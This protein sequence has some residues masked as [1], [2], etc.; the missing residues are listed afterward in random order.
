MAKIFPFRAYRYA[1]SAGPLEKL[2]TQPYDKISPEMQQRYLANDPKN[3]VRVILGERFPTDTDTDNVYTRAANHFAEWIAD[4]TLVQDAEAA[5]YAYYQEFDVPDEPG[6]RAVRKGLIALGEVVDYDAEVV[7]RHELTLA[8]PKKDRRQVLEHTLAHFGQIFMLYGDPQQTVDRILDEATAAPPLARLTDEYGVIHTLWAVTAPDKIAAI[9][10]N[11]AD[12]KL[13]IADGHHR[14]E[15]A[16]AFHKDRPELADARVVM[17]TLVN[18]YAPGLKILGTH[19]LV[20]NL[21]SFDPREF[22]NQAGRDF[23]ITAFDSVAEMRRR[24]NKHNAEKVEIG[25]VFAADPKAYLLEIPRQPGDLDVKILH[26]TLLGEYLGISEAAVRDEQHLKYV[27]G[28]D[29]AA[30]LVAQGEYQIGFLLEPPTIDQVAQISF[31]GGVMPQK[32]T[33]F[34]PKLLTGMAIYRLER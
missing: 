15:T 20:K 12:N 11:L 14:Y 6:V 28:I 1:P 19:R 33:D 9:E 5:F 25:V 16:L 32:S 7:H 18:M 2:I 31:G 22:L 30:Q 23:T 27:R 10:E 29:A 13:L 4:G 17:M 34:Y 8:G 26:Q 21:P 24:W 3:L